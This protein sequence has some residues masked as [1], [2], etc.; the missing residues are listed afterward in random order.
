[1][2]SITLLLVGLAAATTP[3]QAQGLT[4]FECDEV[5]MAITE[6]S[7]AAAGLLIHVENRN[8]AALRAGGSEDRESG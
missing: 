8:V 6:I 7:R 4:K 1:M 3:V 5:V 2:R